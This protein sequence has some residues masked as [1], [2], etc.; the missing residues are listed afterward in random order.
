MPG[1]SKSKNNAGLIEKGGKNNGMLG[2][3]SF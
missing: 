2:N 1:V 3:H